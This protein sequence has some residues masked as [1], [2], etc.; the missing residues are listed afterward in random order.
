VRGDRPPRDH[1]ELRGAHA[2][3]E[4]LSWGQYAIWLAIGRNPPG[5]FVVPRILAC[6]GLA[7]TVDQVLVALA[8]LGGRHAALRTHVVR[9]ADGPW[10]VVARSV[11]LPVVLEPAGPSAAATGLALARRLR[12]TAIDHATEAPLRVGLVLAGGRVDRIVLAFSHLVADWL[13]TEI[14]LEELR[15]SLAV[16]CPN[17]RR[18]ARSTSPGTNAPTG[19]ATPDGR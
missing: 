17:R 19:P 16:R 1:L 14:V 13:A 18:C 12:S 3:E 6:A 2:D 9:R 15:T 11:R 8:E 4:R 10:Q 5:R 7:P